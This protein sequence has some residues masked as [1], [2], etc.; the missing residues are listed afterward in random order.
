MARSAASKVKKFLDQ[1]L[2]EYLF[3]NQDRLFNNKKENNNLKQIRMKLKEMRQLFEKVEDSKI[4]KPRIY[5]RNLGVDFR[6]L[7]YSIDRDNQEFN[8][9]VQKIYEGLNEVANLI[10][11]EEGERDYS[12]YYYSEETGQY[13]V[14]KL[15][16]NQINQYTRASKSN[17]ALTSGGH[18]D[19]LRTQLKEFAED[20][21]KYMEAQRAF[22][23]HI[24]NFLNILSDFK[25]GFKP[26]ELGYAYELFEEHMR[27]YG[28]VIKY[29]KDGNLIHFKP[30]GSFSSSQGKALTRAFYAQRGN[31][32]WVTEGDVGLTQIK[33]ITDSGGFS[34]SSLAQIEV[35]FNM[36]YKIFFNDEDNAKRVLSINDIKNLVLFFNDFHKQVAGKT[37][38]DIEDEIYARVDN[39]IS[40]I[41]G[42][43]VSFDKK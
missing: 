11:F 37:A 22:N 1:N 32:R 16:H 20:N 31:S 13:Y 7:N 41:G 9:Y 17:S 5:S 4:T 2:E 36:V 34:V 15:S 35:T 14:K 25:G 27:N 30:H 8:M 28:D 29:D 39:I 40:G 38:E 23:E 42:I 26:G 43:K 6:Y 24:S 33:S 18:L 3:A 19:Q 21:K 12:I 10:K